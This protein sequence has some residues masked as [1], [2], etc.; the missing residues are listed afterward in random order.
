MALRRRGLAP[1]PFMTGFLR[2]CW[3]YVSTDSVCFSRFAISHA[4]RYRVLAICY[5]PRRA[6]LPA[7][8]TTAPPFTAG[9][10]T[11]RRLP[12]I[13]SKI[14]LRARARRALRGAP[15]SACPAHGSRFCVNFQ[16]SRCVPQRPFSGAR[17]I[18]AYLCC[19][20]A[21]DRQVVLVEPIWFH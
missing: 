7:V 15:R 14:L 13:V 4:L 6:R 8:G 12:Y 17:L 20:A 9:R 3:F 11:P 2:C 21:G 19:N 1:L 10:P 16:I 5:Q 18:W